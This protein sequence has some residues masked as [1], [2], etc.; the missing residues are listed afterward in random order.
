MVAI[1]ILV[2]AVALILYQTGIFSTAQPPPSER[3]DFAA[4]ATPEDNPADANEPA[5]KSNFSRKAA[6]IGQ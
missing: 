2:V 6:P 1:G 4:P 3:A 5:P